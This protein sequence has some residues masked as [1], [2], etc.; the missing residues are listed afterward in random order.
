MLESPQQP[1]ALASL[2]KKAL[3]L[4]ARREHS[5]KELETKLTQ[6]CAPEQGHAIAPVL[7]RLVEQGLLSDA[8]FAEAYVNMR[9]RKGYG[10]VRIAMELN[11]K[12]VTTALVE[13]AL[14]EREDWYE[15]LEDT[16]RKKFRSS[17]T[18]FAEKAKQMRFLQY[19]GHRSDDIRQLLDS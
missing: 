6:K 12:G 11:E 18:D 14:A 17:P 8:R 4:L 16:W 5:R 9:A 13:Q 10:P 1:D 15:L 2:R 3:D 7:D 19:R